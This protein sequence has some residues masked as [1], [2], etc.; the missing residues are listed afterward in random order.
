MK[1]GLSSLI[2]SAVMMGM[3][4]YI[5]I[6]TKNSRDLS[7][8]LYRLYSNFMESKIV[9]IQFDPWGIIN[10]EY[11]TDNDGRGDR[12]YFYLSKSVKEENAIYLL[13][14]FA[15]WIDLDRN[16]YFSNNEKFFKNDFEQKDKEILNNPKDFYLKI[17][18]ENRKP[19]K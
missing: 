4:S 9:A 1:K 17:S 14:N 6:S 16:G 11:D 12:R 10:V 3:I 18:Q 5:S 2:I 13:D 7:K 19:F 15:V 8:E